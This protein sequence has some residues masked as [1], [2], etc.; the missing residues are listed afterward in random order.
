MD[1]N[2]PPIASLDWQSAQDNAMLLQSQPLYIHGYHCRLVNFEQIQCS[3]TAAQVVAGIE[4]KFSNERLRA[5]ATLT[6]AWG[7][8]RKHD[9]LESAWQY[10]ITIDPLQCVRGKLKFSVD[11][12]E[13]P[14]DGGDELNAAATFY[15]VISP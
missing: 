6:L 9:S 2:F 15:L 5:V 8:K 3:W 13:M 11:L 7:R 10:R 14:C 12:E 1:I 4:K